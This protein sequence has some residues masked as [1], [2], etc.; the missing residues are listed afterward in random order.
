MVQAAHCDGCTR[1]AFTLGED[2]LD[3]AEVDVCWGD[4]VDALM[5]ADMVVV[6]DEGTNAFTMSSRAIR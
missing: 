1:Y 3:P 2:C 6:L 4:I 5:I